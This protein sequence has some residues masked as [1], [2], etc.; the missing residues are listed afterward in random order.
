MSRDNLR[1]ALSLALQAIP[2]DAV[3]GMSYP[4][5]TKMAGMDISGIKSV[6]VR[7]IAQNALDGKKDIFEGA[8]VE[9]LKGPD[10]K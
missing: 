4:T 6:N 2:E 8:T 5:G 9:I 3:T 10:K 7:K 1:L